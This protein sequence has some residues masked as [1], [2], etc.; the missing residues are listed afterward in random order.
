MKRSILS[1]TVF[2]VLATTLITTT[3]LAA[4]LATAQEREA[5][6]CSGLNETIGLAL[7][8]RGNLYTAE[9]TTGNVYCLPPGDEPV[10]YARV[11]G[12]P[13]SIAVDRLRNVFVGT[14]AGPIFLISLDGSVVETYRC[15]SSPMGLDIDRDG[16]L[17]VATLKGDVIRVARSDFSLL[18]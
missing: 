10:F 8:S 6:L 15:A 4:T 14:K 16:D 18:Q 9:K 12:T 11:P 2:V 3:S 1:R 17:I 13:T 5:M 7:D